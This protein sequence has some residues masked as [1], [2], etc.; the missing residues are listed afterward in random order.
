MDVRLVIFDLDGTLVDSSRDLADS[1]NGMLADLGA[2]AL[3]VAAVTAMV[4]EGAQVLVQR[5]LAASGLTP[6]TPRALELFLAQY[7]QRLTAH[8]RPYDGVPAVLETLHGQGRQLAVLTNKPQ[9]PTDEI[10]RRLGLAPW[11]THVVGGD[12]AAGRKPAPAGLLRITSAA[13]V[14]PGDTLLVG[15]SP[16]DLHTARAAGCRICIAR[17]GFGWRVEGVSLRGDESFAD[18]PAQLPGIIESLPSNTAAAPLPGTAPPR[19]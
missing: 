17:Y 6:D 1:V 2:P 10:L 7:S 16:V 13:G 5:A 9:L 12:T 19:T 8:T 4:G 18:A 14:D 15:D 3:P 11:F